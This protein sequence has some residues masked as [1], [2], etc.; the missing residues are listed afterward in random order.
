MK[1]NET[2]KVQDEL[3]QGV[4]ILRESTKVTIQNLLTVKSI[5]TILLTVVFSY[6]AIDGRI[7]GEQFLTIFSV[8][9]AFYF[10]TQ[11]QKNSGGEE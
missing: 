7:S 3:V 9:I 11:Y 8:V 10:G 4:A 6:L 1:E 5:V 2:N